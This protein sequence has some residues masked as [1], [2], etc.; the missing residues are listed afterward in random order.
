MEPGWTDAPPT[1][2][3]LQAGKR[4]MVLG[5]SSAAWGLGGRGHDWAGRGRAWAVPRDVTMECVYTLMAAC[6]GIL[7]LGSCWLAG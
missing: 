6:R 4:I 2:G 5:G 1:I 7:C 3:R